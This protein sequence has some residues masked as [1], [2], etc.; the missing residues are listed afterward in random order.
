MRSPLKRHASIEHL[1][2][3]PDFS[4]ANRGI[5]Q[6]P[7]GGRAPVREWALRIARRSTGALPPRGY[8]Q[9]LKRP[10]GNMG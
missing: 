7:S 8:L 4:T 2:V 10:R 1:R 3:Y 9:L 5:L 6:L